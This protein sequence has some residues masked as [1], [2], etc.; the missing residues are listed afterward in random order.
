MYDDRADSRHVAA[1]PL[2]ELL[3]RSPPFSGLEAAVLESEVG[4]RIAIVALVNYFCSSHELRE[5]T[6]E[7]GQSILHNLLDKAL[8]HPRISGLSHV[9]EA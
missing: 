8:N 3:L 6:M 1:V 9:R 5:R 7:F 4:P 2:D